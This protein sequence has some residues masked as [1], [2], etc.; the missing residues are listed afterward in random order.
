MGEPIEGTLD[1]FFRVGSPAA[2]SGSA[3]ASSPPS[4]PNLFQAPLELID[5]YVAPRL[6]LPVEVLPFRPNLGIYFVLESWESGRTTPSEATTIDGFLEIPGVAG[7]WTFASSSRIRQRRIFTSGDF[8]VTLFYLDA[9]PEEVG[10]R[11]AEPLTTLWTRES[12]EP[13]LAGPFQSMMTWEWN[14]FRPGQDDRDGD[15]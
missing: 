9:P 3:S 11:L 1:E 12:V 10:A 4:L 7:M 14:R 13:L 2:S 15:G 8:K 6:G 5:R